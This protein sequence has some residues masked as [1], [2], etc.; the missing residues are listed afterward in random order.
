MLTVA[1]LNSYESYDEQ[2][3]MKFDV[4]TIH[5]RLVG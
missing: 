1:L 3:T 2:L 5:F 4:L